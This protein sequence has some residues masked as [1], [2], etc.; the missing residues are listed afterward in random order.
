METI[1][2]N[3]KRT[4]KVISFCLVLVTVFSFTLTDIALVNYIKS[5]GW[6]YLCSVEV[7]I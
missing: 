3:K 5:N 7:G 6:G 2:L 4:S 1:F